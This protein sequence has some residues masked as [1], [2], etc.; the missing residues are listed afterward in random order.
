MFNTKECPKNGGNMFLWNTGKSLPDYMA[1][2]P[3]STKSYFS[4]LQTKNLHK[5][6]TY[7]LMIPQNVDSQVT[8][9]SVPFWTVWTMKF[10]FNATLMFHVTIHMMPMLIST[11]TFTAFKLTS[12]R[13]LLHNSVSF[14]W[15]VNS[16]WKQIFK[17]MTSS[18]RMKNV[19]M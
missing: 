19:P 15:S 7:L 4:T 12:V 1:S 18:F 8:L 16:L 5:K 17:N 3:F 9:L 2:H 11:S 10:W 14:H 6:I 13:L